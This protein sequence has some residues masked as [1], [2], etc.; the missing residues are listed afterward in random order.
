MASDG[1]YV[2]HS[3]QEVAPPYGYPAYAASPYE[4]A[5]FAQ[6]V[7]RPPA[8][9]AASQSHTSHPPPQPYNAPPPAYPAQSPYGPPPYGVAPSPTAQWTGEGWAH[10][11]HTFPP[12]HPPGQEAPYNSNNVRPDVPPGQGGGE[13]RAYQSGP[14]RPDIHR[15]DERPS[16]PTE[17]PPQSKIRK[18]RGSEPP[19]PASPSAPLGLDF[20]KLLESYRLVM[21]STTTLSHESQPSRIPFSPE[22]M[23]HM[24]QAA[25]YGVQALDS[26]TKRAALDLQRGP[27]DRSPD[28]SDANGS[29]T[30]QQSENPPATEGQTCLGCNATSTPEWR[31][32]PMGPRTLCNACGL[33]YA[34]L[35]KK[36]NRDFTRARTASGSRQGGQG[37]SLIDDSA[38]ASSGEGGSDDEDSYGSQDR[39]SDGGYHGRE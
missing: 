34:K 36:R 28:E 3:P 39:R 10:Y 2:Y 32:G 17:A 1:R 35:I 21:D 5:Q 23:E 33:V 24:I 26:A 18:D 14:S 11:A 25:T 38:P 15:T 27:N 6:N 31:R 8:R 4:P 19:A 12:P 37:H 20:I 7:P 16:R 9:P 22:S 29:K 13:H 30:R